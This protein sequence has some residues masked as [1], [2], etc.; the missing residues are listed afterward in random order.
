MLRGTVFGAGVAGADG[1]PADTGLDTGSAIGTDVFGLDSLEAAG[2]RSSI[3]FGFF[4]V[5]DAARAKPPSNATNKKP[6]ML[7]LKDAH[8]P[9]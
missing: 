7:P 5:P 9:C 8:A 2:R 6:T 4:A 3:A 1:A